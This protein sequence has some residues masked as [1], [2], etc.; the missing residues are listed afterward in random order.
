MLSL[1][2]TDLRRTFRDKLFLIVCIIGAVFAIIMPL[3]Y[4]LIFTGLGEMELGEFR[5]ALDAKTMFFSAFSPGGDFGLIVPILIA[6]IICKDF[7]YGTVRN[8]IIAGKSR[9][10]I[11]MS[12]FTTSTIAMCTVILAQALLTLLISLI[13]FDYQQGGFT[14]GDFGYLLLSVLFSLLV[15]VFISALVSFLAV[16]MKNTGLAVVMYVAVSFLFTIV[17][18]II[19]I[20]GLTVDPE[21][22][23]AVTILEFLNNTNIFTSGLIG[24]GTTY[25]FEDVM[26]ILM[27]TIG[28]TAVFLALGLL[29]F[30]K[31]DLK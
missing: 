5:M 24:T 20:A 1:L 2:K 26:Y 9:S 6:I 28:G 16:F 17:G 8:K 30:N 15:Y 14:A 19:M 4:V 12:L 11:F 13:F 29:V 25:T 7:S 18:S 22:T 21:N 10:A 3:L 23:T 31:K 27:P